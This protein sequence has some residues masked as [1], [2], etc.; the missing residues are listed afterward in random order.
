[1]GP[2]VRPVGMPEGP[3]SEPASRRRLLMRLWTLLGLGAVAELGWVTASFLR[4][5]PRASS[6]LGVV[7]AGPLE[8]FEPGSV[9]A[10]PAGQFYLV[11]LKDGG[12]LALHRECTHLGCTVPWVAAEGR[13]K[14]PCHGS[15]FDITG[16]VLNPPAPRPLDLLAVRIENG[17]VK[18]DVS[19]RQRRSAFDPSQEVSS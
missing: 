12:L 7:V 15:A 9:T 10:F 18:I 17:I 14:C 5:R 4:P 11:R 13:F 16:A 1:M 6:E 19:K 8:R 2:A 3:A